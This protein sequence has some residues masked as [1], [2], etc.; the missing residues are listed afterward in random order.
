MHLKT[1]RA[2][3]TVTVSHTYHARYPGVGELL[4]LIF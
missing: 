1:Q 4:D 2:E 3:Y